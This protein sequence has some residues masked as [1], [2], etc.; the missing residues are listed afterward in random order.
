MESPPKRLKRSILQR[1]K[2][3]SGMKI[4]EKRVPQ[5]GRIEVNYRGRS[6]DLR[7]SCVPT[8]HGESIVMRILDKEN[9]SFG[10]PQLG[11]LSDDQ[12]KFERLITLPAACCW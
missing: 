8:N 10:L 11:F 6:L 9:I 4:A 5:D 7:V 1:I 12:Q 3:M 2:I